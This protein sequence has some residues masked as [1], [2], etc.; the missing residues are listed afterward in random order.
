M[1]SLKSESSSLASKVSRLRAPENLA[2][3][4]FIANTA[5]R[6]QMRWT[7]S[8][9]EN[10][11]QSVA[12]Q[13][14]IFLDATLA[15]RQAVCEG[16]GLSVLPDYVIADDLAAGRLIQVLPRWELPRGGIHAVFPAARFRP[17][18]VRAFVELLAER[19]KLRQSAS[20]N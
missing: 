4:P 14:S 17:A 9:K 20:K 11:H 10:E 19:E 5:L 15:V 13:A 18:K 1:L 8:L 6:E 7:F 12:M 16:A 2:T 3:L